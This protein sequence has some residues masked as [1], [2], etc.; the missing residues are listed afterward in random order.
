MHPHQ[1]V[2]LDWD[3]L[4]IFHVTAQ[5]GSFTHAG[6][7]LQLSQ[8]AVS[9]QISSLEH[10]LNTVLFHRHARGLLL[11]EQGEVLFRTVQDMVLKIES[12]RARMVESR[13]RPTGEL[14]ITTTVGIGTNWLSP[15]LSEFLELYPG[16]N[17]RLILTDSELDLSMREAD[18]A[19][20]VREP[21]QPDLI[22]RRLFTIHFHAYASVN[23][24]KNYGQPRNVADLD[25]HRLI[26]FSGEAGNYLNN[27]NNLQ[28]LG[29]EA[30][31]PRVMNM[32][33][34]NMT[35]LARMVETGAGIAV[36]PDYLVESQ[37]GLVRLLPEAD[38][39]ELD[40]Y[41][42]YPE[43]LKS[44]ARVQVFRDFLVT[45]AQRWDS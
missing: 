34:N 31:S 38:M 28:E 17:V 4:R 37:M 40:C 12:A 45:N 7:V 3:R 29:R 39:P 6:D 35:A 16:I 26:S 44:T 30:K 5:A 41:L 32:S 33:V 24:I 20:R 1:G 11:T 42:V 13:D 10:D 22:R 18:V 43:E 2:P 25:R 27:I 8:S 19:L 21:S 15:R 14:R 36:L 23:Y 9:R